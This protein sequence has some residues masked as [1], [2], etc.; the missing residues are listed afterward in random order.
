[1][2]F[3]FPSSAGKWL[4][5]LL[6][7][8]NCI[9]L[10]N[11]STSE[12]TLYLIVHLTL[13]SELLFLSH[14]WIVWLYI[15][16]GQIYNQIYRP[17][18]VVYLIKKPDNY[19]RSNKEINPSHPS[20]T[21]TAQSRIHA[22]EA[23]FWIQIP[24]SAIAFIQFQERLFTNSTMSC[25]QT[26]LFLNNYHSFPS[27]YFTYMQTNHANSLRKSSSASRLSNWLKCTRLMSTDWIPK[28]AT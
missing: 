15:L 18:L 19:C 8:Y 9:S 17:L 26:S 11:R 14:F 21:S 2:R 5:L 13:T 22:T 4:W 6:L 28:Q 24:H 27:K 16:Y 12:F 23:S 20:T 7:W 1:M 25:K 3:F 10:Y